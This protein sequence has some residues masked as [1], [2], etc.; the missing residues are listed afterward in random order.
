MD[1]L[2]FFHARFQNTIW[3]FLLILG[4]WG[5]FR[6]I[7]GHSVNGNYM[8]AFFIGELTLV[9]QVIIGGVLWLT[10]HGGNL[11]R[12]DMHLLYGAFSVVFLPFVFLYWLRGDASNRAQWVLSFSILFQ[13]G[14]IA[15]FGSAL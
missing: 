15:R 7:R 14:V 10:G 4:L 5:L 8:G 12:P 1:A 11:A 2:V 6:A 9:L 13:F 3:L